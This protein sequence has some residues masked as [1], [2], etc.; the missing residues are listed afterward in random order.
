ML[1]GDE[2]IKVETQIKGAEKLYQTTYPSEYE[3]SSDNAFSGS[4][5]D[6]DPLLTKEE[7]SLSFFDWLDLQL[8]TEKGQGFFTWLNKK[9]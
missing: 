7:K 8:P 3:P 2:V 4:L 5:G 6:N 9:Q 1:K